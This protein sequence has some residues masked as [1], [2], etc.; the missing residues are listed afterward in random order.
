MALIPNLFEGLPIEL[1]PTQ[2]LQGLV[3]LLSRAVVF[4]ADAFLTQHLLQGRHGYNRQLLSH[5]LLTL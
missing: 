5:F 3:D 4:V 2:R 1:L